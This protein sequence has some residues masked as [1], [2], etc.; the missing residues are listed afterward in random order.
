M[1]WN[2]LFAVAGVCLLLFGLWLVWAPLMFIVAGV[3]LLVLG[4]VR[5]VPD[6][7]DA[8]G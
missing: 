7:S 5:E 6:G 8:R 4:L 2:G 3:G 1:I